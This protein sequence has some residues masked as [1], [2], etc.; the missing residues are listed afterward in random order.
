MCCTEMIAIQ[1]SYSLC[2]LLRIQCKL[3]SHVMRKW[4]K[5][6]E[7]KKKTN[8]GK[9]IYYRKKRNRIHLKFIRWS[10]LLS[11]SCGVVC[12]RQP[13]L[14]CIMNCVSDFDKKLFFFSSHYILQRKS[15]RSL[16]IRWNN[17]IIISKFIR[18]MCAINNTKIIL[19]AHGQKTQNTQNYVRKWRL[20]IY[21][22][23]KSRRIRIWQK[24]YVHCTYIHVYII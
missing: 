12:T 11:Y 18:R 24:W 5:L 3:G 4:F 9:S 20:H 1:N 21:D 17:K 22:F 8:A 19:H 7:R 10:D 2:Y 6:A 23:I 15:G 13:I 16:N 14:S